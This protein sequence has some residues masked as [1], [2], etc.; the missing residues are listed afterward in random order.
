MR[1]AFRQLSMVVVVLALG[2][3]W[4]CGV[5]GS[6]VDET[7][8]AGTPPE[9]LDQ[10]QA[11]WASESANKPHGVV[12][13][14]DVSGSP[15][16]LRLSGKTRLDAPSTLLPGPIFPNNVHYLFLGDAQVGAEKGLLVLEG[17]SIALTGGTLGEVIPSTVTAR[18]QLADGGT[19]P[20][21]VL[22]VQR[23]SSSG[24][25]PEVTFPSD[26][27]DAKDALFFSDPVATQ[28]SNVTLSGFTRGVLVTATGSTP[29]SGNVT[30]ASAGR[31]YWST[32]SHVETQ[33]RTVDCTRFAL[34]GPTDGGTLTSADFTTPPPVPAAMIGSGAR[35]TLRPD[36]A[37]SEGSFQL[38]QA[39]TEQ[40]LLV[41]ARIEVS[42][43]SQPFTLKTDERV[44]VPVVFR[45]TTLKG[46]A[47][48]ADLQ[49]T[50]SGKDA[51]RVAV[52]Q[53]ETV[54][55]QLWG[56]VG[57]SGPIAGP[58]LAVPIAIVTPFVA[59]GEWLTCLFSTCPKPYPTWMQA[60]TAARFHIIVEGKLPPGTYEANVTVTGRNYAP[61]TVPVQFT[62]T[63]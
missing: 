42:Y 27:S 30:V 21:V 55:G 18:T 39:V 32:Y 57:D 35:V 25:K 61:F 5:H 10:L 3:S 34:G 49:I 54:V 7:P 11:R 47:V 4:G 9:T 52:D 63:Q 22:A 37:K 53:V 45:E 28:P 31:M 48:L 6:E 60:G 44:L 1:L 16:E 23:D 29:I 56:A 12:A 26:W 58:I 15:L 8:D 38:T 13:S 14:F 2:G 20:A 50:G 51:V 41:P 33:T 46:D 24:G 40:G 36:G 43:G 59:V 17:S 62:I 19:A